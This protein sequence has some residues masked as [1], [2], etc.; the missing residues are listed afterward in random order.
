EALLQATGAVRQVMFVDACRNGSEPGKAT[1]TRSFDAFRAAEGMAELFSTK[2]GHISFESDQLGSG[3]FTHFLVKGLQGEAAGRDGLVTFRD[4]AD[5]VTD[6]VS[7]F[8]FQGGQ[9]QVPFENGEHR[10]D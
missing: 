3:V 4:L 7:G 8:G 5:Y 1:G 6:G 9:M 2:L 10:G